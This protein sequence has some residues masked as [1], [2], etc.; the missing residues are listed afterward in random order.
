MRLVVVVVLVARS[1]SVDACLAPPPVV[2]VAA[3]GL[4]VPGYF[5]GAHSL[6]M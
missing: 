6:C 2:A 5:A 3:L 4:E 1:T